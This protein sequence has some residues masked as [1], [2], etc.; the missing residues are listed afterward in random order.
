MIQVHVGVD[1]HAAISSVSPAQPAQGT[2]SDIAG[3]WFQLALL[4]NL[5]VFGTGP[6][7]RRLG[8]VLV[9][10]EGSRHIQRADLTSE[11]LWGSWRNISWRTER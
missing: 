9:R 5:L 3:G 1:A 11:G 7:R 2:P 4:L 10:P 8:C 6:R